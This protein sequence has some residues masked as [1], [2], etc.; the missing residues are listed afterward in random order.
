MQTLHSEIDTILSFL[1]AQKSLE[2][3]IQ[4]IIQC[5]VTPKISLEW[6]RIN[7]RSIIISF[8]FLKYNIR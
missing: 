7:N 5:P 6:F 1:K 2:I 3:M 8:L 4:H